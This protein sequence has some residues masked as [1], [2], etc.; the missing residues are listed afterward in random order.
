MS[1][2]KTVALVLWN[3]PEIITIHRK[4]GVIYT[5]EINAIHTNCIKHAPETLTT[6]RDNKFSVQWS[7]RTGLELLS[8]KHK[9]WK[10]ISLNSRNSEIA[11]GI[12][13]RESA[14]RILY[15]FIIIASCEKSNDPSLTNFDL[16]NDELLFINK[17]LRKLKR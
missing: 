13:L 11:T 15:L 12:T 9:D 14:K 5:R 4:S 3:Y 16:E 7:S 8:I 6:P 2:Q 17:T 10:S 1:D